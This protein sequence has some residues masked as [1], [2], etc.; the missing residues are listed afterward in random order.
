MGCIYGDRDNLSPYFEFP[1]F[2][3]ISSSNYTLCLLTRRVHSMLSFIFLVPHASFDYRHMIEP[4][5]PLGLPCV[6]VGYCVEHK[7]Y[8]CYDP[9]ADPRA[10]HLLFQNMPLSS[11]TFHF[12][13]SLPPTTTLN[14]LL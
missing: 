2:H 13:L 8:R 1:K 3:L 6:F 7:G 4:S 12:I 14:N 5:S 10:G 11:R 9:R